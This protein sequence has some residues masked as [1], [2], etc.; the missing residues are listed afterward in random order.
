MLF[1]SLSFLIFFPSVAILN[2]LVPRRVR[3]LLLLVASYVF[4]ISWRPEYILIILASSVISYFTAIWIEEAEDQNRRQ[5]ILWLGICTNLAF[6]LIFKYF[7]FFNENF[8]DIFEYFNLSYPISNHDF[9]APLGISFYTLQILGY[10]LDVYH[11]RIKPE[12]RAVIFMLFVAFFPQLAAGPI[13]RARNMLPQFLREH[14]FD[15]ERVVNGSLRI[16]W[17]FFKKLVIADRLAL[18]VNAVYDAPMQ[19]TGN[20]LIF[21]TYAFAFQIYCDFS[22]YSDIAIGV[23]RIL[24][25]DLMENFQQPYFSK[26]IPDFWRT[27]HISLSTWLRD[28][29]F[30]PLRRSLLR[31]DTPKHG[32]FTALL[33]PPM[34]TMLVS[35]LWHGAAWTFIIWGGLHG[36]F[37]I[38]DNLWNQYLSQKLGFVKLP[39]FLRTGIGIFITFHLVNFSWIFFRANTFE[40]AIYIIKNLF[41]NL[42]LSSTGIS[43]IMPGGKYELLIVVCAI[44]LME[45]IHLLQH[46]KIDL[47]AYALR[48]PMWLRW[49]AYYALVLAI[50]VFGVFGVTEFIYIQF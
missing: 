42:R 36:A 46:Y 47:R 10:L 8:R 29:I 41:V 4:Y 35:G 44:L 14:S 16:L 30:Y 7:N 28:Y 13:E 22:A 27:W 37:L 49:S 24:G 3:W 1:N 20:P 12:R 6:L 11:K 26:S 40:D 15:Y 23:A 25:F 32:Y 5:R 43:S 31:T 33:I 45:F 19:Y 17:G 39:Q 2:F 48:L 21:A 18:L 34:V 38:I 9:I 50:L